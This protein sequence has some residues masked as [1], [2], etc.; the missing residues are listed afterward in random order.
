MTH[1]LVKLL[2]RESFCEK[3]VIQINIEVLLFLASPSHKITL[4]Y[5]KFRK[6]ICCLLVSEVLTRDENCWKTCHV[7]IILT[8]KRIYQHLSFQYS[9][10]VKLPLLMNDRL[11]DRP[12]SEVPFIGRA[13]QIM[14]TSF[15]L[16]IPFIFQYPLAL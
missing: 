8:N 13:C 4:C 6:N 1:F 12:F 11:T 16:Y 15:W 2:S 3:F 9:N 5:V 10:F 7:D 14:T